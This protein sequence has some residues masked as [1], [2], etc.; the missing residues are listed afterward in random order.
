MDEQKLL[1][2]GI[3]LEY[4]TMVW[5]F[6]ECIFVLLAAVMSGSIA[7]LGFGIDSVI[8]IFANIVA[9]RHLQG[10]D[11]KKEK[12]P[13]HLIGIAF[14]GV[15]VYI[16]TESIFTLINGEHANPSLLGIVSLSLTVIAMFVLAHKKAKVGKTIPNNVLKAEANVTRADGFLALATLLGVVLNSYFGLW[17]AD[18]LAGI[19]IVVYGIREGIHAFRET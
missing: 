17:W 7:L 10:E 1:E 4:A 16:L 6:L 13:L 15:A 8:E 12:V 19:V 3:R 9:I 14:F 2:K 18:P 5:N 11:L